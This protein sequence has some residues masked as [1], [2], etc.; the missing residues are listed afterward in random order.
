MGLVSRVGHARAAL[1]WGA[2]GVAAAP[3]SLLV[4]LALAFHDRG[5]AAAAVAGG[6]LLLAV[7]AAFLLDDPAAAVVGA[8]PRSPWWDLASRLLFLV[9]LC[10][11]IGLTGWAWQRLEPT[12]QPWLAPLVADCAAVTAVAAAAVL[13]RA[14]RSTP[15]DA[16]SAG[17]AFLVIGLALFRPD[18][19]GFELLPG[20]GQASPAE[21]GAWLV[22]AV[23]AV[24]V[25]LSSAVGRG[26][27]LA[28]GRGPR[29]AVDA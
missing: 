11:A 2:L 20:A 16:V 26:P 1:P 12:P 25:V 24:A 15:G 5:W 21:V 4:T 3:G 29:L 18:W 6:M 17:V 7:P 14:G 23:I 10:G 27:R 28:V 9:G 19:R 22:V 8:S 13:R